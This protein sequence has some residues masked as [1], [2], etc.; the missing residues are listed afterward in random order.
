MELCIRRPHILY[1]SAQALVQENKDRTDPERA[2]QELS[3]EAELNEIKRLITSLRKEIFFK[4]SIATYNSLN[5]S[6][7]MQNTPKILHIVCHGK[8]D[9]LEFEDENGIAAPISGESLK[10]NCSNSNLQLLFLASCHSSDFGKA[11]CGHVPHIICCTAAISDTSAIEFTIG[12]YQRLFEGETIRQ[13]FDGAQNRV[14][15]DTE[16]K[17]YVLY[18]ENGNHDTII[19]PGLRL[20]EPHIDMA[21]YPITDL[22][23]TRE[24]KL[25]EGRQILLNKAYYEARK[26]TNGIVFITG[27]AHMGKTF[28]A[29]QLGYRY[30]ERASVNNTEAL[31]YLHLKWAR[32]IGSVSSIDNICSYKKF[33]QY[34]GLQAGFTDDQF[35]QLLQ[36]KLED[37]KKKLQ[38]IVL[39][40]DDP[41]CLPQ[42][43]ITKFLGLGHTNP[44]LRLVI[45]LRSKEPK[46]TRRSQQLIQE[47]LTMDIK[48]TSLNPHPAAQY[49]LY[50]CL[51]NCPREQEYVK[52]ISGSKMP[53]LGTKLESLE[54]IPGKLFELS[55]VLHDKNFS[56]QPPT[57][58]SILDDFRKIWSEK[59]S[60]EEATQK[61][62]EA[63][64]DEHKCGFQQAGHLGQSQPLQRQF[65]NSQDENFSAGLFAAGLF[66]NMPPVPVFPP[67]SFA[68]DLNDLNSN[69][70]TRQGT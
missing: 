35:F 67:S 45:V 58:D 5:A 25:I 54:G 44:F 22:D 59:M 47:K 39:I 24:Q 4:Q 19:F 20:G 68:P 14:Q 15:S 21:P 52:S 1:L 42:N 37:V 13:A 30:C 56:E 2:F 28:L 41:A 48:L 49:L 43:T 29:Q 63:S 40:L 51:R 62:A 8:S 34:F 69:Q 53:V 23:R 17:K 27:G 65:S 60:S 46:F 6:M 57:W 10:R 70:L 31:F 38:K 55:R 33:M 36:T 64:S 26:D 9:S 32:S 18:P 12:L 16:R 61:A 66:A 11:M 3:I 7:S 50:I